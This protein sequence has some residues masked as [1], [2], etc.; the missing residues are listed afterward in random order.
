MAEIIERIAVRTPDD[1]GV[2]PV[3]PERRTLR[4][5]DFAVLWG[6]LAVSLLVMVAGSLLVPGLGTQQAVLAVIIGT[7]LGTCLLSLVGIA[8]TDM[9]VPTMVALRGP[10][11]IRGSFATSGLNILQLVGWAALEIIIMAQA[12]KALSNEYLGFSG[13]YFWLILFGVIGTLLAMGGPIVVVR[14]WMQRFGIW[15]V[16][17]AAA[18]L[19]FHLFD[20]YDMGAIWRR[21]GAGGF[22]NFWQGV[23]VVV[24]LPISWLPLVCDYSR[25]GRRAIPAAAGTY[26]GYAI[27]NTWFFILGVMYVQALQTDPGGFTTALVEM[28]LP[29]TLGWLALVVLLFGE[30]DEA[31]ANIYSTAV[32]IQNLVPKFKQQF[33]ALAV[34]IIAVI[35]AIS[36]DLVQYENFLFLIGGVFVPVFGIFLADYF[37]LRHRRYEVDQ[38]YEHSGSYWYTSGFSIIALVVWVCGFFLYAFAAQPP[39]LLEH[40]DFV[41]WVPHWV[42]YVGGTIPGLIF[43]STAYWIAAR[44]LLRGG[45]KR[46][47]SAPATPQPGGARQ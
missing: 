36:I 10:M 23:D 28:M 14:Q 44:F 6:D 22:P 24:A 46:P 33:L 7:A 1:W 45:T 29:F 5:F 15:I 26:I 31:F 3:P 9:G 38:L 40:L 35:V 37:L 20:A 17:A 32:T 19:T 47:L 43:S 27:A 13:Y 18:W 11:G 42:T 2:E 21:D 16:I 39:W 25:F 4:A 8:G 30:T 12:A 41:S 34:G